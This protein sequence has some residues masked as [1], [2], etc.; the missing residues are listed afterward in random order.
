M[1][2][3]ALWCGKRILRMKIVFD[4]ADCAKKLQ[5]QLRSVFDRGCCS[6]VSACSMRISQV[7]SVES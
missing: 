4:D 6:G 3:A 1:G 2:K 7:L 5:S